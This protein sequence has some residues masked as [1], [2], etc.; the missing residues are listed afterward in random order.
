MSNYEVSY[1]SLAGFK[2]AV[3]RQLNNCIAS[4]TGTS[5]IL[6]VQ[7]DLEILINRWR[8]YEDSWGVFILE[9][10]PILDD[11]RYKLLCDNHAC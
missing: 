11:V 4:T 7:S 8:K 5:N 6:S 2:A 3:T 1:R 9:R 10:E